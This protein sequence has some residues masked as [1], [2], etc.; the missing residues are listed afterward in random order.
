VVADRIG[1]AFT[2]ITGGVACVAA[3]G[4][5]ALRLPLLRE[6]VRPIYVERGILA[7][8]PEDLGTKSL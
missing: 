1:P 8:S 5:F 4:W 6:Q 3:A 2:I 7:A